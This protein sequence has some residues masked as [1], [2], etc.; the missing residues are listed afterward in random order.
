MQGIRSTMIAFTVLCFCPFIPFI[1]NI[2]ND[3]VKNK[4][5]S[6][7]IDSVIIFYLIKLYNTSTSDL[8]KLTFATTWFFIISK[9]SC[10]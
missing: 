5:N 10:C 2:I 9:A 1:E 3:M 6:N 7:K 4:A 8:N